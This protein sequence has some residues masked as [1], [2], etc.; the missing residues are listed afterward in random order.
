MEEPTGRFMVKQ[1][2]N[3]KK[4][5]REWEHLLQTRRLH[6]CRQQARVVQITAEI[7]VVFFPDSVMD[8]AV[9]GNEAWSE[10]VRSRGR[11]W[12]TVRP[13][14]RQTTFPSTRRSSERRK[15]EEE[16]DRS[17]ASF[18]FFFFLIHTGCLHPA[19]NDAA[20][21]QAMASSPQAIPFLAELSFFAAFT[22]HLA[23]PAQVH[24]Q[25]FA[26]PTHHNAMSAM[27]KGDL[28]Q[29]DGLTETFSHGH[30]FEYGHT[31]LISRK[32][33][34]WVIYAQLWWLC[35]NLAPR[36]RE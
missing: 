12:P 8:W 4:I 25:I 36:F 26:L 20:L 5:K 17:T 21:W 27:S 11:R 24:Q 7:T 13:V 3:S 10:T 14:S 33:Q 18:F 31:H 19:A 16:E 6:Y 34:S 23:L 9:E 15:T 28:C 30:A 22:L 35:K 29:G 2:W 32:S 1:H